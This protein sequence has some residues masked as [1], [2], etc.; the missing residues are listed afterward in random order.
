LNLKRQDFFGLRNRA[1]SFTP[2]MRLNAQ[3]FV[4]EVVREAL[5]EMD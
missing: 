1:K 5:K 2:R 3:F 4:A